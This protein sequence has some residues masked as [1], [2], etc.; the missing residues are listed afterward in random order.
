MADLVVIGRPTGNPDNPQPGVDLT[1]FGAGEHI[2]IS[3]QREVVY[4]ADLS[5][6]NGS[7]LN[8]SQLKPKQPRLLRDGGVLRLGALVLKVQ[9]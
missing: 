7:F 8:N 9:F 5:S 4:V 1:P 6:R 2:Q 3:H